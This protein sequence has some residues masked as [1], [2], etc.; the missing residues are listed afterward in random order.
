MSDI[1]YLEA[2]EVSK[3]FGRRNRSKTAVDGVSLSVKAGD[4][5]GIV[6]ESGSGKSTMARMLVGLLPPDKGLVAFNGDDVSQL[7]GK[8]K[9]DFRKDVQMF[10]RIHTRGLN[11]R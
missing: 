11:P 6:G 7:R 3:V 9:S 8:Q 5:V 1:S 4:S 10:F 2:L